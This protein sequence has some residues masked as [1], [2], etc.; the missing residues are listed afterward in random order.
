MYG[1]VGPELN[2][3][4]QYTDVR[5][6]VDAWAN[7]GVTNNGLVLVSTGADGGDHS[8]STGCSWPS[9]T[10]GSATRRGRAAMPRPWAA[11]PRTVK[12]LLARRRGLGDRRCRVQ[13]QGPLAPATRRPRGVRQ[14]ADADRQAEAVVYQVD[15]AAGG[16]HLHLRAQRQVALDPAAHRV[17]AERHA[18]GQPQPA[19]RRALALPRGE[20]SIVHGGRG[21][22]IYRGGLLPAVAGLAVIGR[23]GDRGLGVG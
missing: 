2:S 9:A 7:G 11:A 23:A 3:F 8:G 13:P 20:P 6:L 22:T 5:L 12:R 16:L 18:P 19:A 17:Q 4:Y 10:S 15:Q 21:T 14:L 1:M